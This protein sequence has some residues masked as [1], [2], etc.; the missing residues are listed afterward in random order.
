[1]NCHQGQALA[2][3]KRSD[4]DAEEAAVQAV[5][6]ERRQE[7]AAQLKLAEKELRQQY[8]ALTKQKEAE[9]RRRQWQLARVEHQ[10]ALRELLSVDE[11][12]HSSQDVVED[13]DV[14]DGAP[15]ASPA[16]TAIASTPNSQLQSQ[17]QSRDQSLRSTNNTLMDVSYVSATAEHVLPTA[18]AATPDVLVR[19]SRKR[20]NPELQAL[21]ERLAKVRQRSDNDGERMQDLLMPDLET[22]VR[23]EAAVLEEAGA[24]DVESVREAKPR[25]T[26]QPELGEAAAQVLASKPLEASDVQVR[27]VLG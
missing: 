11:I 22:S 17:P 13:A 8:L 23:S 16:R 10:P 3:V 20:W 6:E 19:Q 27:T 18:I 1:M 15:T 9:L 24:T 14:S 21:K 12:W 26:W 7:H 2:A 25:A 5:E 4:A